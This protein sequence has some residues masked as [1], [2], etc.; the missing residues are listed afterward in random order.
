MGGPP[1]G[2]FFS[3]PDQMTSLKA[4]KTKT[5]AGR[6]CHGTSAVQI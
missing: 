3:V 6:P 5:W 1:M 2:I 4:F